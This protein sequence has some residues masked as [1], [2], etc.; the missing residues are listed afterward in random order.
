MDCNRQT[1]K[2]AVV[3]LFALPTW[4]VAENKKEYRFN[5][6]VKSTVSIINQYGP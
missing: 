4:A 3:A 5:V 6:G 2:F 1:A